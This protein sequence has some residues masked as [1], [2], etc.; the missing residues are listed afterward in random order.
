MA[1]FSRLK[2]WSMVM[3]TALVPFEDYSASEFDR[4]VHKIKMLR[5]KALKFRSDMANTK[6]VSLRT[7]V[8]NTK[9]INEATKKL[10]EAGVV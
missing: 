4:K 8:Q 10:K 3:G 7:W 9:N 6:V 1:G 2:L 5:R